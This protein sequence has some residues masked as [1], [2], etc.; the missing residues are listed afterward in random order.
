[1]Y[2]DRYNLT[3]CASNASVASDDELTI[4]K[5]GKSYNKTTPST[6]RAQLRPLVVAT[7]RLAARPPELIGSR[8]S[9][10]VH[11]THP[12][13]MVL[14]DHP[15]D[16]KKRGQ[17]SQ[18]RRSSSSELGISPRRHNARSRSVR[19]S[20]Q[21]SDGHDASS[22]SHSSVVKNIGRA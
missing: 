2:R 16:W 4:G 11:A 17:L 9:V 6:R 7:S 3:C 10:H 19:S 12:T 21:T 18:K 13:R 20:E 15:M 1:M 22:A 14:V 5:K 8:Y